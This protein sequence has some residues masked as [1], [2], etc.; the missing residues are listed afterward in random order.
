MV[1]ALWQDISDWVQTEEQGPRFL[2]LFTAEP[3]QAP[4]GTEA[5]QVDQWAFIPASDLLLVVGE[6]IVGISAEGFGAADA[7]PGHERMSFDE[8]M[9]GKKEK[10]KEVENDE[11]E[12]KKSKDKEKKTVLVEHC[13][14][15]DRHLM[16]AWDVH[17]LGN[18]MLSQVPKAT[19]GGFGS[20]SGR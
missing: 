18:V 20:S 5:P 6:G 10:V 19:C 1:S 17:G 12:K 14:L 7:K 9:A 8:A 4:D 11:K 13:H 3:P 15:E 2:S 16:A